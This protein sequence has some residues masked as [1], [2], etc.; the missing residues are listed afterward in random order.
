MP[1]LKAFPSPLA[2]GMVAA[3][4]LD[5]LLR[6]GIFAIPLTSLTSYLPSRFHQVIA[7]ALFSEECA[8][9]NNDLLNFLGFFFGKVCWESLQK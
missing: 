2:L 4:D 8:M 5:A 9:K 3:E 6:N 1:A 7:D